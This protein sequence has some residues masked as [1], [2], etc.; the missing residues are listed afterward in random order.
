MSN[1]EKAA[2]QALE[3]MTLAREALRWIGDVYR[4][5]DDEAGECASC[6]ERSYKPHAKDCKRAN[7]ISAISTTIKSLNDALDNKQAEPVV[8]KALTKP[9]PQ[10]DKEQVGPVADNEI[11]NPSY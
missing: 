6:G 9:A 8:D 7:A 1:L 10:V 3:A 5:I 2:R 11:G 4:D